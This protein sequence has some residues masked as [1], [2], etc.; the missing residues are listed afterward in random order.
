MMVIECN[1]LFER[2]YAYGMNKNLVCKK[3]EIK[4]NKIIK[5]QKMFNF[6][7]ITKEDIKKHNLKWP[8]IPDHPYKMIIFGG[9][10]SGNTNA[11]LNLINHE[12][13]TDKIILYAKDSYG[14]KYQLLINKRERAGLKV[15][16]L[17]KS[18]Y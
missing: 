16:K 7:Y 3:V 14:T 4:Y 17:F 12:P 15:L 8:E 9:S 6:G 1:H 5:Q 18:F 11:L 10:G 2:K 13:D